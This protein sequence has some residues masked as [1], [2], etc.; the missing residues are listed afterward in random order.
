MQ[1]RPHVITEQT[2][3]L[4][5]ADEDFLEDQEQPPAD[6]GSRPL[7]AKQINLAAFF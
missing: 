6:S 4:K 2:C 7:D 1:T 5:E 3:V